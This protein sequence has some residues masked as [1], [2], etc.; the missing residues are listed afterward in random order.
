MYSISTPLSEKVQWCQNSLWLNYSQNKCSCQH[1]RSG[2]SGKLSEL[3]VHLLHFAS[4]A[5]WAGCISFHVEWFPTARLGPRRKGPAVPGVPA[6]HSAWQAKL[7]FHSPTSLSSAHYGEL[8]PESH[9]L[10]LIQI[11]VFPLAGKPTTFH[12]DTVYSSLDLLLSFLLS[13][14]FHLVLSSSCWTSFQGLS[15]DLPAFDPPSRPSIL[16]MGSGSPLGPV[17]ASF[18]ALKCTF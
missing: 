1:S 13:Y 14:L 2:H 10:A 4:Q 17:A 6:A 9:S 15:A 16:A 5:S 7:C 3:G 12:G 11:L 18:Q 8:R